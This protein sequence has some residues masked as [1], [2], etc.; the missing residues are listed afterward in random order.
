MTK[1][2]LLDAGER[3]AVTFVE[4]FLTVWLLFGDSQADQ[5]FT[6]TNV[7]GGL[8][9]GALAAGK[10]LLASLKGRRDSASLADAVGPPVG[11]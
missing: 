1:R 4:G 10:S 9:A 3:V 2:F 7:K 8:V 11:P 5:L 6:W